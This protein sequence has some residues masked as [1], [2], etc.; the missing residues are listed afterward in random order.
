MRQME[1]W[2]FTLYAHQCMIWHTLHSMDLFGLGPLIIS[3]NYVNMGLTFKKNCVSKPC[4]FRNKKNQSQTCVDDFLQK[5][6]FLVLIRFKNFA[7]F[8]TTSTA[9]Y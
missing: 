9:S 6:T 2:I 3:W 7:D 4:M 1:S 5:K 8:H